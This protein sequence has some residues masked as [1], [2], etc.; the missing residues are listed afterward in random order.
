MDALSLTLLKT[1]VTTAVSLATFELLLAK[2]FRKRWFEVMFGDPSSLKTIVEGLLSIFLGAFSA[3]YILQPSSD[4][5]GWRSKGNAALWY[6]VVIA[7]VLALICSATYGILH[8]GGQ[9]DNLL[10]M[11]LAGAFVS[12]IGIVACQA[13]G[14]SF[15][16]SEGL[17]VPLFIILILVPAAVFWGLCDCSFPDYLDKGPLTR[18]AVDTAATD[19]LVVSVRWL[20]HA[21]F[22]L[23]LLG[24]GILFG[25]VAGVLTGLSIGRARA[26]FVGVG[27]GSHRWL[28]RRDR[29][30]SCV[31]GM[32]Q[33]Q[34]SGDLSDNGGDQLAAADL[35]ILHHPDGTTPRGTTTMAQ[36]RVPIPPILQCC[37]DTGNLSGSSKSAY[38]VC[39]LDQVGATPRSCSG[40]TQP[41][42][43]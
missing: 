40:R 7:M 14:D 32:A 16:K 3:L 4:A 15:W 12:T 19:V 31:C 41:K 9:L 17:S 20:P 28:P 36:S 10:A 29:R 39:C 1:V 35:C 23:S 8:I 21:R 42:M 33:Q 26:V 11:V 27:A 13:I 30:P 24:L 25:S 5:D 2:G 37:Q 38:R 22:S 6:F 43:G 34:A 18:Q